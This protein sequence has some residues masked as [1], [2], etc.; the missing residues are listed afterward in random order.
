MTSVAI[1]LWHG[2]ASVTHGDDP[3][4]VRAL[5]VENCHNGT[6]PYRTPNGTSERRVFSVPAVAWERCHEHGSTAHPLS[7]STN[8]ILRVGNKCE[9]RGV[10]VDA[11]ALCQTIE[12]TNRALENVPPRS[13]DELL[14]DGV[15][16][17]RDGEHSH[18]LARGH[19]G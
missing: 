1:N 15:G 14:L 10:I 5:E 13:R 2:C 18:P 16:I 3:P 17:G 9:D 12:A 4:V 19:R 11:G 8:S 7:S 6:L